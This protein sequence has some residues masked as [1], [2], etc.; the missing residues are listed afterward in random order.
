[1]YYKV[2]WNERQIIDLKK[3]KNI[4]IAK[5]TVHYLVT[6]KTVVMCIGSSITLA[7]RQ[8]DKLGKT[9]F[10]F[11]P[12]YS[13]CRFDLVQFLQKAVYTSQWWQPAD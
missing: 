2:N 6:S 10:N 8:P 12:L 11:Y 9:Q 5:I 1:M 3:T 7:M 4:C 13:D